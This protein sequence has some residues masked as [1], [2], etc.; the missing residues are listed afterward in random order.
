MSCLKIDAKYQ[1]LAKE[2]NGMKKIINLFLLL[3][4]L[5]ALVGCGKGE[6]I[7]TPN[8]PNALV[9]AVMYN[10]EIYYTTGEQIPAEVDESAIVGEITSV[11]PLSQWPNENEQAN[12]GDVGASLAVTSEGF[13][14]MVNNEWTIFEKQRN[15]QNIPTL[16]E[17]SQMKYEEVNEVLSGRTI[18]ELRD[19]WG[20]PIESNEYGD[21]WQADSSMIITVKYDE[22]TN[23]GIVESCEL[24]CGTPLAPTD[25]ISVAEVNGPY[26][27]VQLSI[28]DTWEFEICDVDDKKLVSSSY[29]IHLKPAAESDGYIEVGYNDNFGVCGTGLETKSVTVANNEASIGY[30]DGNTN[31]AFIHWI[32]PDGDLENINVL[33]N[34]D[35]GEEYLDELLEILDSIQFNEENQTGGIG[36]QKVSSELGIDDGYLNAS[37][38]N[39]SS[40]GATVV[41]NYSIN[42]GDEAGTKE[43]LCFGTY[44]P[45]AKKVGGEWVELEYKT[46]GDAAF[47]DIAYII[48]EN[49]ETTYN[50]DWEWL[51]GSLEPGEY[52]ISIQLN[53]EAWI[54]AYFILR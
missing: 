40:T 46:E 18:N 51:Y 8:T 32:E 54:Y 3:A 49:E 28:P 20:D 2:H 14:V 48:K 26:G 16:A 6:N 30:Y 24:V 19:A 13:L 43:E 38:R 41:L 50:Y 10:G 23:S 52:Q 47:E 25:E 9:P 4:F 17:I 42:R 22:Y 33:C 36:I 45:I 53:S 31:W 12:F 21:S 35:W 15:Q 27:S 5:L 37:V 44:L 34:A 29:G 11:V 1:K 7:E 39:V